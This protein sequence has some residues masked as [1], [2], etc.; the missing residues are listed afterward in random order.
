MEVEY[1]WRILY[2]TL[3]NHMLPKATDILLTEQEQARCSLLV[4]LQ[5]NRPDLFRDSIYTPS[6]PEDYEI[7]A[8]ALADP[9]F[10]ALIAEGEKFLGF[11]YVWGGSTPE[12]FFDCSGFVCWVYTHSGVHSLPRTTAAGLYNQCSVIP[13]ELAQPGDLIFFTGTYD[14]PKP[15]IHVGIYVGGGRMLHAGSPIQYTR[16]DTAY[17]QHHFL[18]FGRL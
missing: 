15:I 4:Q 16:I 5:G 9:Q 17:W 2:V 6:L 1:P 3:Q 13:P 14:T 12:T 8:D 11:P 10:A 18:A 7:P